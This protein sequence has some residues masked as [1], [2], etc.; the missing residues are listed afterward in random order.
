MKTKA[1]CL[2]LLASVV[3][4]GCGKV[5]FVSERTG[6]PQIHMMK[7]DGTDTE[8]LSNG[9]MEDRTPDASPDWKKIAYSSLHNG[10][11]NIYVMHL[12]GGG[13]QQVTSGNNP[14]FGPRWSPDRET[15]AYSESDGNSRKIFTIIPGINLPPN[16]VTSP[17]AGKSDSGGHDFVN[18]G[19]DI[20]FSRFKQ[21]YG[22]NAFH[23]LYMQDAE[24]NNPPVLVPN[25]ARDPVKPCVSH[26]GQL[27]AY[28]TRYPKLT[29]SHIQKIVIQKVQGWDRVIEFAL[30]P[31]VHQFV[32]SIKGLGFS[33]D[34]K[35]LY[36]AASCT[37][38]AGTGNDTTEIFSIKLDG[39]GLKRLTENQ[40]SDYSPT[41][42]RKSLFGF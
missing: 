35:R 30:P 13:A 23:Q 21:G 15:I 20:V 36:V 33:H 7:P 2:L 41:G 14:K 42:L 4:M 27:L 1:W 40:V 17:P 25:Q 8:R 3:L 37:V 34:D 16:Q 22:I 26:N 12:N 38:N 24:G 5:V 9:Q 31:P 18:D 19:R 39:T 29:H 32:P 28:V 11:R 10:E 6:Q